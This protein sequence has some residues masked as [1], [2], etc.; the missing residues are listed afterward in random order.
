M[1][2]NASIRYE[3]EGIDALTWGALITVLF[4][5]FLLLSAKNDAFNLQV[6]DSYARNLESLSQIDG[7]D[8]LRVVFIGNSRFRYALDIG[9]DPLERV[10][11]NDGRFMRSVQIADDGANYGWYQSYEAQILKL[12]PDAVVMLDTLITNSPIESSGS[13]RK[14]SETLRSYIILKLKGSSI[15]AST[16]EN[17]T[18]RHTD[19]ACLKDYKTW[20][21]QDR[22][23]STALRDRHDI[24]DK[25][26]N[27]VAA[28][29]FVE[30]LV[31]LGIP[32]VMVRLPD[33]KE[34]L[35]EY[36]VPDLLR[37]GVRADTGANSTQ[38]T[39][40][41]SNMA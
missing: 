38:R 1:N 39:R 13:L 10:P 24:S 22:I 2:E 12:K 7:Q 32:V 20:M 3:K 25:N 5:V 4:A 36:G 41:K 31:G 26:Q 17:R 28:R 35:D 37:A 8:D 23:V 16:T 29:V 9:F 15:A 14:L 18:F 40:S 6:Y 21:I 33:L 30:K 34:I 19:S 27:I 11:L